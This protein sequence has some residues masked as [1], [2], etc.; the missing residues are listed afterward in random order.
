M[1]ET[2]WKWCFEGIVVLFNYHI[3]ANRLNYNFKISQILLYYEPMFISFIFRQQTTQFIF[4]N[5]K[6]FFPLLISKRA[7]SITRFCTFVIRFL[8]P[9][10]CIHVWE[11]EQC[12]A[13]TPHTKCPT[14]LYWL[15]GNRREMTP[16]T[17]I[18]IGV[19]FSHLHSLSIWYRVIGDGCTRDMC[20]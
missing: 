20:N 15:S 8:S 17:T 1:P 6:L 13:R 2:I 14:Q 18:T 19:V 5:S 3:Q 7:T 10:L 9:N 12:R 11:G 16:I 4:F